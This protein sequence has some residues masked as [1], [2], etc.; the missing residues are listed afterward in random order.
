[1]ARLCASSAQQRV[2]SRLDK[3]GDHEGV[4]PRREQRGPK[5]QSHEELS[6]RR[7]HCSGIVGKRPGQ[8]AEEG[9]RR[10]TRAPER[11]AREKN[12]RLHKNVLGDRNGGRRRIRAPSQSLRDIALTGDRSQR[13]E[14]LGFRWR[15]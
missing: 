6:L 12:L 1:V 10:H 3:P 2:I 14:A 9:I 4:K 15:W 11:S 8:V 5:E 7:K 13:R